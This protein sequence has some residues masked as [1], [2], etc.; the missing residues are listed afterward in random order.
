MATVKTW[1]DLE[2]ALK[3]VAKEALTES[4]EEM[5][6]IVKEN[7]QDLVYNQYDPTQYERTG[8][9]KDSLVASDVEEKGNMF[10]TS[11]HHDTD[12]IHANSDLGQHA[13]LID[14]RSSIDTIAE[15]VHDGY[16]PNIFNDKVDYIWMYPR[17]Y[18]YVSWK[19]IKYNG[20]YKVAMQRSLE[21]KGIK[22]K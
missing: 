5:K 2:K 22:T 6:D 16:A 1:K 21:K 4:K 3:Q 11:I 17:P 8:Q 13:S 18:M 15:I 12:L 14:G 10:E 9:L 20:K 7:I 19:D